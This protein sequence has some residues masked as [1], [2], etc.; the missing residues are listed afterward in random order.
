MV[1]GG[2]CYWMGGKIFWQADGPFKGFVALFAVLLCYL[3]SI[4]MPLV[5]AFGVGVKGRRIVCSVLFVCQGV[6]M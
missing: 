5:A 2:G 1:G 3:Y 4:C 6:K